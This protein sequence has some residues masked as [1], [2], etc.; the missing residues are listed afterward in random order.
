MTTFTDEQWENFEFVVSDI[1]KL[2]SLISLVNTLILHPENQ[3]HSIR[4]RAQGKWSLT[5]ESA[6]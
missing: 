5:G 1:P 6:H 3:G 2:A 4:I